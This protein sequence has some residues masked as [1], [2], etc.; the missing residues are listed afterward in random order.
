MW[1]EARFATWVEGHSPAEHVAAPVGRRI[2][3]KPP[4]APE[5]AVSHLVSALLPLAESY[6]L[7][8]FRMS[9]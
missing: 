3:N 4:S 7:P 9:S 8:H 5:A 1:D 6:P 2:K